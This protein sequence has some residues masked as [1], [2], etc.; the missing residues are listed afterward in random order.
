[1]LSI[2]NIFCI[3]LIAVVTAAA[4]H[5]TAYIHGRARR[6]LLRF[7]FFFV[8]TA[9]A[10]IS[11]IYS[12]GK[13]AFLLSWEAMGLASAGLVA[14]ESEEKSVKKATW[15]YLLACHAGACALML[16]GVLLSRPDAY[17][18]AFVCAFVGCALKIGLPPFHSW[19][20]EAHPAAPAPASA[21]MSAAMIPLGFFVLIKFFGADMPCETAPGDRVS[22]PNRF[23]GMNN[24]SD[25]E[26]PYCYLWAGRS[27]RLAEVCDL[28][29]R[30]RFCE[31]D[32]GC[33]GNNDS[34]G[35]SSWYVWCVLG[36]YPFTGSRYYL[37]GSPS[38]DHA[39]IDLPNGTLKIEVER[40]SATAIYPAG[41]E[42]NG[43]DFAEPWLPLDC[44]ERGGT[45]KFRLSDKPSGRSPIPEWL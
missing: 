22:I 31:G 12:S 15:I 17:M 1:M 45:L 40:E 27:D 25:M 5:A 24:E 20:P 19:L 16:A 29:R 26:T 3:P 43:M 2:E 44:I 13:I 34:G 21:I 18:A 32:G 11:V 7:W 4:I 23:E 39:E 42:F 28:V 35:L 6:H 41:Y 10:M 9:A 8:A 38:V 30:C 37:L 14:F 33:P 36:I